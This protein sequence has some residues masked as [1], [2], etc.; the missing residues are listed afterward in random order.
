MSTGYIPFDKYQISVAMEEPIT[1]YTFNRCT[2]RLLYNDKKLLDYLNNI[3]TTTFTS[4][5]CGEINILSGG[6]EIQLD[7][8]YINAEFERRGFYPSGGISAIVDAVDYI[9][10]NPL[11][12]AQIGELLYVSGQV[13]NIYSFATS[14]IFIPPSDHVLESHRNVLLQDDLAD[15][16]ALIWDE[17][18]SKWVN[19]SAGGNFRTNLKFVTFANY[20]GAPLQ[21]I[22]TDTGTFNLSAFE[23]NEYGLLSNI[24]GVSWRNLRSLI[25]ECSIPNANSSLSATY[26]PS[27]LTGVI[28]NTNS[29]TTHVDKILEYIP[30][31]A[32]DSIDILVSNGAEYK[33]VGAFLETVIPLYQEVDLMYLK[34]NV[35]TTTIPATQLTSGYINKD[36]VENAQTLIWTNLSGS[37]YESQ[38]LTNWGQVFPIEINE[39]VTKTDITIYGNNSAIESNGFI[40]VD[41]ENNIVDGY[42]N[43]TDS[44]NYWSFIL[45][46]SVNNTPLTGNLLN[47]NGV[48]FSD[49]IPQASFRHGAGY[50]Y[51]IERLPRVDYQWPTK[52]IN[53]VAYA[54]KNYKTYYAPNIITVSQSAATVTT[55]TIYN[56]LRVRFYYHHQR[57]TVS[58]AFSNNILTVNCPNSTDISQFYI[59]RFTDSSY[60][61]KL[62]AGG[63]NYFAMSST[64][65]IINLASLSPTL[66]FTTCNITRAQ[67]YWNADHNYPLNENLLTPGAEEY[68]G[69]GVVCTYITK[70]PSNAVCTNLGFGVNTDHDDHDKYFTFYINYSVQVTI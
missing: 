16:Q 25:V 57:S 42:L 15:G 48:A 4:G 6:G 13:N 68:G 66:L 61:T 56:Y 1:D 59:Y 17:Q 30:L 53:N 60:T 29:T 32:N 45:T 64:N 7:Y 36:T 3:S 70:S 8:N 23:T 10:I 40:S 35:E 58:L 46:G 27:S 2:N 31:T 62:P 69:H 20:D 44:T 54:I 24:T 33:I 39:Y 38:T 18:L 63:T 65:N 14:A 52:C 21:D 22:Y 28:V 49:S 47:S 9:G 51:L 43:A 26:F 37:L 19:K 55:S 5:I 67:A 41:W 12:A 11:S 50:N 34:G